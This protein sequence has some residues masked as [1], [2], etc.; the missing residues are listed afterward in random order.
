MLNGMGPILPQVNAAPKEA[1]PTPVK[2]QSAS[3]DPQNS[4]DKGSFPIPHKEVHKPA[5]DSVTKSQGTSDTDNIA[6]P[7]APQK[8]ANKP[9]PEKKVEGDGTGLTKEKALAVFAQRMQSEFNLPPEEVIS[10]FANMDDAALAQAPEQSA[11]AFIQQLPI[12]DG[13]KVKAHEIYSEMLAWSAAAN[14]TSEL[15]A[16][17]QTAQIKVMSEK[18]VALQ[19]RLKNLDQLSDKFFMSGTFKRNT[20]MT[21]VDLPTDMRSTEDAALAASAFRSKSEALPLE[22]EGQVSGSQI[23]DAMD[24]DVQADVDATDGNAKATAEGELPPWNLEDADFVE[25]DPATKAGKIATDSILDVSSADAE[26]T[27]I[28]SLL[29]KLNTSADSVMESES[30]TAS[31]AP[32]AFSDSETNGES[33]GEESQPELANLESLNNKEARKGSEFA[34]KPMNPTKAEMNE[35]VSQIMNRAQALVKDGGGEMKVRL[36]PEGMGE[37]NLKV[38]VHNGEV[39]IEMVAANDQTKQL[40]EKGL[41]EL[42]DSLL[43]H[44]LQVDHIKVETGQ[45]VQQDFMADQRE[46]AERQFQQRFL[47]D[48]MRGNDQ[49][50]F[51]FTNIGSARMPSSQTQDEAVN[52][53]YHPSSKKNP[54][55]K[56]DLVA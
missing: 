53:L 33:G 40:L 20:A 46:S 34:L 51:G 4:A 17:N 27:Q 10:A 31:A 49:R 43:S 55:R 36:N 5:E 39:R 6:A 9:N 11:K 52:S 47:Q 42:K 19:S 50:R 38:S 37:V 54:D 26:I 25:A 30:V 28:E 8:T 44:K 29:N 21:G 23:L 35:N 13:E 16:K 2:A 24:F 45:N 22:S 56:L 14:M 3:V 15:N 41:V 32:S 7:E 18:E 1:A 48:F 12:S